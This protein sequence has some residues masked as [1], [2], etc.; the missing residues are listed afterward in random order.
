MPLSNT[1]VRRIERCKAESKDILDR[2]ARN[3]AELP[4]TLI[5]SLL[6]RVV[7]S[8]DTLTYIVSRT[9]LI[10]W[11][12][13][14]R[15]DLRDDFKTEKAND[16][17]AQDLK[18]K[19]GLC[20]HQARGEKTI[21]LPVENQGNSRRYPNPSLIKTVTRAY[22]WNRRLI[23]GDG[24][25]MTDIA[26]ETGL[27]QRSIARIVQL[28]FLAPDIVEAIIEGSPPRTLTL[29]ALVR[30]VPHDWAEQRRLYGF[31]P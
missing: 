23:A 31:T 5:R 9:A 26:K 11:M 12:T 25:T 14:D 28:A 1:Y 29:T 20:L 4:D 18:V 16:I 24:T 17:I 10:D 30:H 2:K 7:L 6:K 22:L 3:A 13:E 8:K 27:T 19:E 21:V 15:L